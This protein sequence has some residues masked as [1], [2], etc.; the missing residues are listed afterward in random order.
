MQFVSADQPGAQVSGMNIS[1]PAIPTLGV[2]ESRT[3]KITVKA[4]KA[5]Q[6]QFTGKAKSSEITRELV[7]TETTNFFE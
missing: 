3:Y 4:L 7:K 6:V 2:G 1:F 5:G